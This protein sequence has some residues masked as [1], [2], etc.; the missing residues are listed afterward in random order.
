MNEFVGP[1]GLKVTEICFD[2]HAYTG[3]KCKYFRA[4]VVGLLNISSRHIS[5]ICLNQIQLNFCL[6]FDNWLQFLQLH[7]NGFF[8]PPISELHDEVEGV[9]TITSIFQV[10]IH[11]FLMGL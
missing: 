5:D 4:A 10:F 8:H 2:L 6:S 1:W 3:T 7:Q 9:W 11:V